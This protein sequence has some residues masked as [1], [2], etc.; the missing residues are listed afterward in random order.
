[1]LKQSSSWQVTRWRN[2]RIPLRWK[3]SALQT[4]ST[5]HKRHISFLS[6]TP[7][8]NF[9]TKINICYTQGGQRKACEVTTFVMPLQPKLERADKILWNSRV[10][11]SVKKNLVSVS[12]HA[13]RQTWRSQEMHLLQTHQNDNIR[14]RESDEERGNEMPYSPG[15]QTQR[16]VPGSSRQEPSFWH[17]WDSHAFT[18][19]SQ[20]GH[21]KP[22][23]QLH[24]NEPGVLTQMPSCS[25]GDPCSHSSMSSLQSTPL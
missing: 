11:N 17:G 6:T 12:L 23:V 14:W 9:F 8:Q 20:R 25:H 16:K 15:M 2:I 4:K 7:F 19:V 13:C 5:G 10:Q 3:H 1:M 21:V 22:C 24:A 18:F